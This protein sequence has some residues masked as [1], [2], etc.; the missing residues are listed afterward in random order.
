VALKANSCIQKQENTLPISMIMKDATCK[1]TD[2]NCGLTNLDP[3]NKT[4]D[5][6]LNLNVLD[7][8]TIK[9]PV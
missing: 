4:Y 1:P 5:F 3:S 2:K 8:S 7:V 6:T 9:D